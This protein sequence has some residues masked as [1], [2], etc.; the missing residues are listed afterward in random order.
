VNNASAPWV[1][2]Y[3]CQQSGHCRER[4]LVL[5]ALHIDYRLVQVDDTYILLVSPTDASRAY[6]E[7]RAYEA[8]NAEW[9]V[10]EKPL[11]RVSSGVSGVIGYCVVL[12]TVFVVEQ[13]QSFALDWWNAG[14]TYSVLIREGELWRTVTAL[15]LHADVLHLLGNLVLGSL[16]VLFVCHGLGT[17]LAWFSILLTGALGNWVNAWLQPADHTSVGASTAVFGALGILIALQWK[18]RSQYTQRRRLWHGAPLVVGA[19]LLGFLGTAGTNTD[20]LAHITGM[21]S[22]VLFGILWGQV[23][24]QWHL[25]PRHQRVLAWMTL[26]I[27]VFSWVCAFL[28][29]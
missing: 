26:L 29:G 2:I 13:R 16:F 5:E 10:E 4:A 9:P 7:L 19:V 11:P 28:S 12:I 25:T 3:R 18:R 8:E 24:Q 1:A 20:V 23:A 14:K 17:G 6:T 22:G 15:S 27:L 21:L